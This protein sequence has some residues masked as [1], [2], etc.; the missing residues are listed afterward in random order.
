MV[1]AASPGESQCTPPDPVTLTRTDGGKAPHVL[2]ELADDRTG[3]GVESLAAD[4]Q[5]EL[6]PA[7]LE[8]ELQGSIQGGEVE[9]LFVHL[10]SS[11]RAGRV[12]FCFSRGCR[13][14]GDS[15]KHLVW[16]LSLLILSLVQ[17]SSQHLLCI[18]PY[19]ELRIPGGKTGT[20]LSC[21]QRAC[22]LVSAAGPRLRNA[23][24]RYANT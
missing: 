15:P 19:T 14:C 8:S 4:A 16:T 12:L 5:V 21:P 10:V 11:E 23:V 3:P 2:E 7:G 9:L 1:Y 18:R 6:D 13:K 20:C 22:H 17:H 24:H